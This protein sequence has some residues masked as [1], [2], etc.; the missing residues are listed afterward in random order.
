MKIVP[1]QNFKG[2][3]IHYG[4]RIN[5]NNYRQWLYD[6]LNSNPPTEEELDMI[7][8]MPLDEEKLVMDEIKLLTIIEHRYMVKINKHMSDIDTWIRLEH[9]LS[10]VQG[11]KTKCLEALTAI[12]IL[13]KD[14]S[15]LD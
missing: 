8:D 12:R 9:Q 1:G 13:K 4:A 5:M 3:R 10:N 11:V 14:S 2:I 6:I 15:I 7:S